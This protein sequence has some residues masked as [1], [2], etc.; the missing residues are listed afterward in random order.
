[1]IQAI[2]TDIEGTT[3][4]IHF[5]KD[6]LFPYADK[7]MQDFVHQHASEPA[8]AAQIDDVRRA[9]GEPSASLEQVVSTL[10]QWIHDDRKITPLKTL[11]GMIW[12][13]GFREG[14]FKAHLYSDTAPCLRAWHTQGMPLYVYSSGSIHAQKLFFAH[15]ECGDLTPLFSGYFDTTSG[16]KRE[17]GSYR[18]IAAAIGVAPEHILFLSDIEQELDAATAAGLHTYW[19]VREGE[20]PKASKHPA[21]ASFTAIDL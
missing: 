21:A 7:A 15:T 14:A 11:Q 3:S 9:L 13:Q 6:V 2:L 19:L 8:V 5:V 17:A 10:R 12:E 20:L 16:G 4:S 1:V 18:H